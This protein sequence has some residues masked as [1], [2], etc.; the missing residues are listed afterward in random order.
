MEITSKL[1]LNHVRNNFFESLVA[2]GNI[3]KLPHIIIY[4]KKNILYPECIKTYSNMPHTCSLFNRLGTR[5]INYTIYHGKQKQT[6][7]RHVT[8]RF[9]ILVM[10]V[11]PRKI[12]CFLKV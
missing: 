10:N 5:V 6:S 1:C 3:S 7:T 4:D 9:D 8:L 2:H 12:T 11:T